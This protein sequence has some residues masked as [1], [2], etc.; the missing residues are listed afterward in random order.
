M[1]TVGF[2]YS[3][4]EGVEWAGPGRI[5]V[6]SFGN[7]GIVQGTFDQVTL[8]QVDNERPEI[9]LTGGSFRAR[10]TSPW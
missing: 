2:I 3:D 4:P 5:H 6:E 7:D 10:I 8:P 1:A 9:T